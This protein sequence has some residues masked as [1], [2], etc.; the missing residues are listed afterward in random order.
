MKTYDQGSSLF[1][2]LLSILVF[3]KSIHMGIGT[4]Q[5]PGIGFLAFGASA[6]LGFL[7]IALFLQATLQGEEAKLT[8]LFAGTLWK[9]VILMIVALVIYAE[10]MPVAGYLISTFLL[11]NFLFWIIKGGKWWWL[12]ALSFFT[13]LVTYYVFSVWLK[14]QFPEGFLG[15]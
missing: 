11:M 9:K 2:L 10:F 7:S 5:N 15:L 3:I 13:T 8:P 14:C 12:L 1:W 4:I 6:L